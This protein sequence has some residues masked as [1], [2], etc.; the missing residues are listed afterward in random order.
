M[1]L[2]EWTNDVWLNKMGSS[3]AMDTRRCGWTLVVLVVETTKHAAQRQSLCEKR[4]TAYTNDH[5]P[6]GP[7]NYVVCTSIVCTRR[8]AIALALSSWLPRGL[9]KMYALCVCM[10]VYVCICYPTD[11]EHLITTDQRGLEENFVGC[12]ERE[13]DG[14][15]WVCVAINTIK[16]YFS[17]KTQITNIFF[18]IFTIKRGSPWTTAADQESK[19]NNL[20]EIQC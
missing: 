14:T 15:W 8:R 16:P 3:L 11:I 6:T 12:W 13:N 19:Q 7:L 9:V 5:R 10:C 4:P 20:S 18:C 2:L 1:L 17:I